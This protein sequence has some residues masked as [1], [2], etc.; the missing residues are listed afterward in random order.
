MNLFD[1]MTH[2][3]DHWTIEVRTSLH[4]NIYH[5][6]DIILPGIYFGPRFGRQSCFSLCSLVFLALLHEIDSEGI[7]LGLRHIASLP[8]SEILFEGVKIT[9]GVI[10]VARYCIMVRFTSSIHIEI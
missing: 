1:L 2:Q 5:V 10:Q 6:A 7:S 8:E 4:R 3:V 9:A